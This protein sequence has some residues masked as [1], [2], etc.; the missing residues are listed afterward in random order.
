VVQV[1][2]EIGVVEVQKVQMVQMVLMGM[3]FTKSLPAIERIMILTMKES[4]LL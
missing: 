2:E 4:S 1:V 3:T